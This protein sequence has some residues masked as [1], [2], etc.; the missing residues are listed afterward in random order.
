MSGAQRVHQAEQLEEKAKNLGIDTS[1]M[2]DYIDS[3][4]YPLPI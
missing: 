2:R 1:T 3:F 4:K